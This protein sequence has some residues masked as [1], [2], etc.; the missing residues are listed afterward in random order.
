MV[1]VWIFFRYTEIMINYMIVLMA[2]IGYELLKILDYQVRL[3]KMALK[4]TNNKVKIK[5]ILSPTFAVAFLC[6]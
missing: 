4:K 6:R 2:T 5:G 1:I 3:L